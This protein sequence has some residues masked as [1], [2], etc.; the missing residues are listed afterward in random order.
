MGRCLSHSTPTNPRLARP[1]LK[2]FVLL[3]RV[4]VSF[5]SQDDHIKCESFF[6]YMCFGLSFV[7]HE[8]VVAKK[9]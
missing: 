2:M 3:S 6:R 9:K 5:A 8:N 7:S 1:C 4:L